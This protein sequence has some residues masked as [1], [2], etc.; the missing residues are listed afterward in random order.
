VFVILTEQKIETNLPAK[1]GALHE[2]GERKAILIDDNCLTF[3]TILPPCLHPSKLSVF[4]PFLLNLSPLH[5]E[6]VFISEDV[7]FPI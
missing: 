7:A 4:N 6:F 3:Y 1:N 5:R 2:E